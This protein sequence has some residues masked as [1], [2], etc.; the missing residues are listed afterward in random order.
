MKPSRAVYKFLY[1][2]IARVSAAYGKLIGILFTSGG[3][4]ELDPAKVTDKA[5]EKICKG[6]LMNA[7]V[8]F[9]SHGK[10]IMEIIP[11]GLRLDPANPE[12]Q[13]VLDNLEA[14]ECLDLFE[15]IL[16]VNS[17]FFTKLLRS[18]FDAVTNLSSKR[19][20]QT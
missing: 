12:D 2:H 11:A 3:F 14:E 9:E 8:I 16:E 18:I 1:P 20:K 6:V 13:K 7:D 10:C 17:G 5:I 15:S 4:F 19:P